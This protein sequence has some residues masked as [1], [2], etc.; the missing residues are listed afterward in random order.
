[1]ADRSRSVCL[2]LPVDTSRNASR[3]ETGKRSDTE[4][5]PETWSFGRFVRGERT[6]PPRSS[7]RP[8]A[9]R[10]AVAT[11][12]RSLAFGE[13]RFRE[14]GRPDGFRGARPLGE[15]G[16]SA[17]EPGGLPARS[18]PRS[19]RTEDRPRIQVVPMRSTAASASQCVP[20]ALLSLTTSG[21]GLVALTRSATGGVNRG[22]QQT[23]RAELPTRI[24]PPNRPPSPLSPESD[25]RRRR[26]SVQ[27]LLPLDAGQP[28][29]CVSAV[30]SSS[31]R[32]RFVR[33]S[34]SRVRSP[35]RSSSL[36]HL[37]KRSERRQPLGPGKRSSTGRPRRW[38]RLS[39]R[40]GRATS[41]PSRV[42][43]GS[44]NG[45]PSGPRP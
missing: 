1:V 36:F 12:L 44:A 45:L 18:A 4:T 19:R 34:K 14:E 13:H 11:A 40:V 30:V 16:G 6:T 3:G 5:G 23:R 10:R 29:G 8:T 15:R 22:V 24:A 35:C 42:S 21:S 33:T 38:P 9:R 27:P 26:A 39:K 25:A 2:G 7:T 31:L 41:Y 28:A 37:A 43:Q 17:K 20:L 32:A